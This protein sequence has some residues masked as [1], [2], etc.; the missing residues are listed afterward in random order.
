MKKKCRLSDVP[1][2]SNHF[3]TFASVGGNMNNEFLLA[4][5]C[6]ALYRAVVAAGGSKYR[7]CC[8]GDYIIY[9]EEEKVNTRTDC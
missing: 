7:L 3:S 1:L 4:E 2:M 9:K 5:T 6:V 8:I